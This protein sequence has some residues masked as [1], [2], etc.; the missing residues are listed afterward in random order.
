MIKTVAE[1][2]KLFKVHKITAERELGETVEAREPQL[3]LL[4]GKILKDDIDN[5][6][7][8]LKEKILQLQKDIAS[9]NRRAQEDINKSLTGIIKK[10]V[11]M[12]YPNEEKVKIKA[13]TNFEIESQIKN[14]TELLYSDNESDESLPSAYNGLGYKNLLKIEF[15]LA[16]FAQEINLL[17]DSIIPLLLIEE[18]ESHMHPQLQQKFIKYITEYINDV[19]NNNVQMV[20]TTHS[21]CISNEVDFSNIRYAK[22]FNN[23]VTYENLSDFVKKEDDNLAFIKKYL[24]I[25]R[26]DLFFADKIILVEGTTERLLVPNMIDKCDNKGYFKKDNLSLKYQYYTILEVGG[27]YAYKFFPFIDFLN[28]PTLI[29]TDFD[30][31]KSNSNNRQE[32]CLVSEA[33]TTSNCTIKEW[34][35]IIKEWDGS[36]KLD[37]KTIISLSNEKKTLNNKH[38]EYQTN[39]DGLCGRSLEEAIE[40]YIS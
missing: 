36:G 39:E 10:A 21:S 22:R 20:I 1:F 14:N 31:T 2:N 40:N 19:F 11:K 25:T 3:S 12:G 37:A 24:T 7:P 26:C 15:E 18:P 32:K 33:E 8:A 13:K 23:W 17:S 30:S 5:T 34:F 9:K 38:I 28:I 4:L 35:R 29:I 16:S 6:F 27:A